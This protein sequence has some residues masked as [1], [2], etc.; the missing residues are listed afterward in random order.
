MNHI[1]KTL[2]YV[3]ANHHHHIWWGMALIILAPRVLHMLRGS[4]P[5]SYIPSPLF[6]KC[7]CVHSVGLSVC[8]LTP[9]GTW[10]AW[11]WHQNAFLIIFPHYFLKQ[12]FF[13]RMEL[14]V[15]LDRLAMGPSFSVPP[16]AVTDL[17]MGGGIWTQVLNLCSR[18][19]THWLISPVPSLPL[20]FEMECHWTSQAGLELSL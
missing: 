20:V 15:W 6:Y 8:V 5:L 19:F 17:Y 1:S 4:L 10:E 11:G 9:A 18:P 3:F 7:V 2:L 14:S 12:G 16:A 13:S